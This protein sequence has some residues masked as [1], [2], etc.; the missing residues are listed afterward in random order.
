MS[1]YLRHEALGEALEALV[2]SHPG[3]F[4]LE[5]IGRSHEGR[6]I[7]LVTAT[8]VASGAAGDKPALWVDGNIHASEVAGS[9]AC[10]HFLTQL[11]HGYG[12]DA[13]ITRALDTRAFYV[14]PRLNPD[15]AELAL[16]DRPRL[17][18]SSTRPY[19][20]EDE[21]IGGLER[22][23]IDGDGRIL[24]MRIAD[25]NGPWKV[26]DQDPRL[27]VRREP[28]EVG[29]RYYRVLPEGL[30][31]RYDGFTVHMRAR[32][33]GLDLNRNYPANWRQEHEQQGAGPYP[34]SEPEV[35][36]AVA[37]ISAHRNI[38]GGVAFHTY[39]GV[40]LRPYSHKAD[41][42][43]PPEDLWTYQK[44]GERGTALT[45]YPNISVFH[46]FRYHP[47]EV[48]T[49][50]F[51]DWMYDH[52]GVFAWTVEIWSP[53]REAGITDYKFI[54][55]YREHPLEDDLKL[56]AW[57]DE[58]LGGEGFVRW[59][60]FEHPQLGPVELGGWNAMTTWTN[61]PPALLEREVDRFPRWLV[62]Q[63][64][65]SPRLEWLSTRLESLGGDAW[66]VEAV[67]V[68]TGW[69]PTNVTRRARDNRLVRGVVVEIGLPAGAA[70][71]SG[72]PRVDLGQLEGRAYKGPSPS[73]WS[74]W[75][76]DE[77]DDR[78]RTEWV[79]RAPAGA[80]IDLSARHDRAGVL[81][82]TLVTG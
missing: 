82:A 67:V 75:G 47:K 54:D 35:G 30:I 56:L 21:P 6:D 78:V 66:R 49:G 60:P 59:Y 12:I 20:H 76:G 8:S 39:S 3:L 53:Q 50:A 62:W 19:P 65:I 13:D 52:L 46:D 74:G 36:A 64:L 70:L 61:P 79:I 4:T 41:D 31:D 81:R 42:T 51:D 37:F 77:T 45:G 2:A 33:E 40:L 10:L 17:I 32:R 34:A 69:L 5:S 26:S 29:G 16:A 73:S 68:N 72:E 43:L 28:T 14:C 11:A 63:A 38:V 9:A 80:R 55:W 22:Q 58:V 71:V 18:R 44:I 1:A 57:N 24:S 23:D 7:W 27:M 25:P 48:I 15:G